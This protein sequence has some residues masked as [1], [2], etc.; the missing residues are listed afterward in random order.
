MVG[1]SE[2]DVDAA[3][4]AKLPSICVTFGYTRI[5]VPELGATA[6]IDHFDEFPAA[7]AKL[8][9]QHFG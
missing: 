9:P 5:P 7:L 6:T 3:K 8:L 4:N 1:D 2:T